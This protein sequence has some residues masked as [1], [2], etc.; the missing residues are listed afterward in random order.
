MVPNLMQ[1]NGCQ[2]PQAVATAFN[3]NGIRRR[4]FELSKQVQGLHIDMALL[5]EKHLKPHERFFILN[6]HFYR[7]DRFP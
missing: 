4:C 6:Y 3:A 7:P 2:S 5:S 1:Q